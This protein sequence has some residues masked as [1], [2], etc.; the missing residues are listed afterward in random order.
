[1]FRR[2]WSACLL[3]SL[4]CLITP[5]ALFAQAQE[6]PFKKADVGDWASYEMKL[7]LNGQTISTTMKQTLK[8]K[9]DK[10]ATVSTEVT[11]MGRS[12]NRDQK[13]PL[14]KPY[15]PSEFLKNQGAND[16]KVEKLEEADD[17]ISVGGKTYK[18]KR[19]KMK[20]EVKQFNTETTTTVWISPD[21]PLF[22]LVKMETELMGRKMVMELTGT[23]K[24]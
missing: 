9:N 20:I 11:T 23:G 13:I 22:G 4:A 6:N 16:A 2:I 8:E 12:F 14:D 24:K 10:E 17:S 3:T 1:M 15:D 18:C 5:A 19:V 7:E 21:V